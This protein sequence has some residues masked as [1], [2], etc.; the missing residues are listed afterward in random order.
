MR[1]GC[2]D[3]FSG[4]PVLL[5][6]RGNHNRWVTIRLVGTHSNRDAVG[7]QVRVTAGSRT[8][9]QE[10]YA[11]SSF[12][13]TDSSWV[14][15]GIGNNQSVDRVQVRWPSEPRRSFAMSQSV[16]SSPSS[17]APLT[18]VPAIATSTAA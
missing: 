15:F 6:N 7:A 10:V 17:K 9:V 18:H 2:P 8:Q 4:Q 5:H 1:D 14:T 13:S 11:G 16:A 3:E 12:A